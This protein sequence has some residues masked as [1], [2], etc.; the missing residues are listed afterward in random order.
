MRVDEVIGR[1]SDMK[2]RAAEARRARRRL[3]RDVDILGGAGG[4]HVER[5]IRR[6]ETD[7]IRLHDLVKAAGNACVP[8]CDLDAIRGRRGRV[9]EH[10]QDRGHAASQ[11][12]GTDEQQ[13]ARDRDHGHEPLQI[14]SERRASHGVA[15]V[16]RIALRDRLIEHA[17]YQLPGGRGRRIGGDR[18]YV[19]GAQDSRLELR[20][21]LIQVQCDLCI[22]GAP[23]QRLD[24]ADDD[25]PEKAGP[26]HDA[27]DDDG[28]G[29]KAQRFERRR[30]EQQR[31][32]RAGDDQHQS[33]QGERDAPPVPDASDD[34]V[35]QRPPG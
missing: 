4:A 13:H 16:E 29:R 1:V 5:G 19:D 26:R 18:Q 34:G 6:A 21:L 20:I 2:Q 22:G 9:S 3:Q 24:Q 35:Q 30:R 27:T 7:E 12:G 32:Q 33:S 14:A 23:A 17:R 10:R 28:R 25:Q 31:Q 11:E 8:G 15:A